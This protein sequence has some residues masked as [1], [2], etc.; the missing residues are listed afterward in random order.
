MN[1]FGQGSTWAGLAALFAM[2]GSIFPQYA[3]PIHALAAASAGVAGAI[4]N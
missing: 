3:L 4:N 1:R 2:L